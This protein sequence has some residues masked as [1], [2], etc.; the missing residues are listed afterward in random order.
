MAFPPRRSAIITESGFITDSRRVA[1]KEEG[2]NF[3]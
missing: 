2:T 3:V 1:D